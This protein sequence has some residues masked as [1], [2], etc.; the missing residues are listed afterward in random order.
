M[1]DTLGCGVPGGTP[2]GRHRYCQS[3]AV[4]SRR[5]PMSRTAQYRSGKIGSG[6]PGGPAS[7]L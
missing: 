3:V 6:T 5:R 4:A 1:P 7:W 2:V